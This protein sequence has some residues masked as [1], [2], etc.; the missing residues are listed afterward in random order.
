MI[1]VIIFL[2][3]FFC[4]IIHAQS[5]NFGKV[6]YDNFGQPLLGF[7][8]LEFRLVNDNGVKSLWGQKTRVFVSDGILNIVLGDV[9]QGASGPFP[10]ELINTHKLEISENG[11][12]LQSVSLSPQQ[13]N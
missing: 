4:A 3:F 12:V 8:I 2:S 9:N 11:V 13:D 7:H 1:R 10:E 5:L 6:L